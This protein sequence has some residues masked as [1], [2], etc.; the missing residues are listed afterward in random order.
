MLRNKLS[1]KNLGVLII[2]GLCVLAIADSV[3]GDIQ[4]DTTLDVQW[5]VKVS[6]LAY[7]SAHDCT[8]SYH[9]YYIQNNSN[10]NLKFAFE[11]THEVYR[12][13]VDPD[14]KSETESRF[15]SDT[16]HQDAPPGV[17]TL[18]NGEDDINWWWNGVDISGAT[19][20]FRIKA[21]TQLRVRSVHHGKDT[22]LFN[23]RKASEVY[24]FD[25]D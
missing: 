12:V 8:E 7:D 19:G 22:H 25:I 16:I 24:T 18:D 3:R 13:A 15:D 14:D 4:S 23:T 11:F 17:D 5:Y 2:T 6:S 1:R 21:Y 20:K 9:Q 10:R